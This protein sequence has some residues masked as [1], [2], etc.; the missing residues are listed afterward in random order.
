VRIGLALVAGL[1]LL[2]VAAGVTLAHAPLVLAGE[3][4]GWTHTTVVR[5]T[6]AT[7][8]CQANEALPRGTVAIRLG[9]TTVLGPEVTVRALSDTRLLTQGVHAPGWEGASVTIPVRP[10]ARTVAPV[11]VCFQL[12]LL[13]SPVAMLG[14]HTGHA[15]AAVAEGK[16][17]PGRMH[18]EYLRAG[19]ES[20]WSMAS[21]IARRLGLG[22][23][24]S[25]T[26]NALLVMALAVALIVL[27]SWLLK[28]EL[29]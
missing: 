8:A 3:N 29:R 2:A 9:L 5:T 7:G 19:R 26:W 21:S 22:R 24:A 25:G 15:T 28:R 6:T 11:R 27:S 20:W 16:P 17:L 4:S 1:L 18:I 13:N 14:W 12:S 10:L 23:A